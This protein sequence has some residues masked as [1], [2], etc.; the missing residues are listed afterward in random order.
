MKARTIDELFAVCSPEVRR[1]THEARSRIK[2]VIPHATERLRAGWGLIG[3]NA[4]AYFAFVVYGDDEEQIP[5]SALDA[6]FVQN[7]GELVKRL[8]SPTPARKAPSPMECGFCNITKEDCPERA[9]GD[10]IAE[11]ATD[12]F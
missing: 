7:L 8:A 3:Y 11:G 4:P 2:S 12:D 5:A 9:A 6:V 1:L 10:Q